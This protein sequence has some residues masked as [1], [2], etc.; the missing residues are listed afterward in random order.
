MHRYQTRTDPETGERYLP[1]RLRGQALM[2]DPMFNKGTAFTRE[3]RA[4]LGIQGLIPPSICTIEKQLERVYEN[5]RLQPN[6][7]DRYLYLVALQDRNETLFYRLLSEH[8]E[9]M[10]PIVYTPTVGLA[11]ERFSH[12]YRRP[13][14]LYITP[15]DTGRIRELLSE[16][17]YSEVSVIVATDGEGILGLGDQGAGGMGIPIGKLALYTLGAGI[18]PARCLPVCLDVGTGN[19]QLRSDPLYLGVQRP[20]LEGEEYYALLDEFVEAVAEVF[21]ATL[22]QWED[23]SK[24]KAWTVLER[25]RDRIC[26]FNDDI[27]GTGAI[28]L[29][30]VL[31]V[32]TATG[33]ELSEHRFVVHG[34]GAGG[35][36][37]I[38][39]L[40]A[41]MSEAGLNETEARAR[42]LG[43]DSHGL[44]VAN[45]P[46]LEA[47]K[48]AFA[49]DP[50][51]LSDWRLDDPNHVTLSDVVTNF[52][53]TVLIG[54]S[55][56][57]G[58]FTEAL[59]REMARHVERPAIFALSNPTS[60]T[61]VLPADALAWSEGR[62]L[63]ATGS[64]FEPVVRGTL[65]HRIGQ[66]NNVFCFPG[67]GLGV[68]AS[69]AR[70]VTDGMLLS[71]A[72][73]VAGEV[74][75]SSVR[76]GCVYPE[77]DDLRPVS[78]AV[79]LAVALTAISEGV[80]EV[81]PESADAEAV[82]AHM[83]AHMW[84]PDYLPYRYEPD[85]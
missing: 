80:A 72:R 7:L 81:G 53:P 44:V 67:I 63:V 9:E 4:E 31:G 62:A 8:V 33:R 61:E 49:T 41:A 17:P 14:G 23:F 39:V 27:Q 57:P 19:A 35:G 52:K 2:T 48:H 1:V 20:R 71:A 10:T 47:F 76:D 85:A 3:E 75:A 15:D 5:Y 32:C 46:G 45:R 84:H 64:P 59:I 37:I 50:A 36:G 60:K 65:H 55:G 6:D 21:P 29:A 28:T 79:A 74:P 56:Q 83:D 16:L 43:L 25:Y 68:I 22:L 13:R 51:L 73:A 26:S 12:I 54:T 11:C 58:C 38:K 82:A 69:A 18:H 34:A 70:C 66:G 77:M 24:Q 40:L 42:V 78:R 30:G